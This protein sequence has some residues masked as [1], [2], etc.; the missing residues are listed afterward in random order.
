MKIFYKTLGCKVNQ[1]ET[2]LIRTK[3]E[4]CGEITTRDIAQAQAIIINTCS[5]THDAESKSR[6]YIRKYKKQNPKTSIIV[7]GCYSQRD[8]KA[9][10]DIADG[11][12]EKYSPYCRQMRGNKRHQFFFRAFKGIH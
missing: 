3:L 10:A 4:A 6:N 1:Y 7:T 8:K 2:E 12:L 9:L 11:I 5:V